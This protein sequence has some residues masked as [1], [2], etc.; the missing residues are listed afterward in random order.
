MGAVPELASVHREQ[1]AT[2]AAADKQKGP[3]EAATFPSHVPNI[4]EKENAVDKRSDTITDRRAARPVCWASKANEYDD[5][6]RHIGIL[7]SSAHAT[8]TDNATRRCGDADAPY[9]VGQ[10]YVDEVAAILWAIDVVQAHVRR[11]A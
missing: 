9:E 8:L 10:F 6:L 1:I 5:A 2:S 11:D 4:P 3:A 7:A